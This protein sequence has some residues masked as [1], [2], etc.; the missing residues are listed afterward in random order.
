M[1]GVVRFEKRKKLNPQYVGPFEILEKIG[2]VAYRIASTPEYANAH[3]VF[4]VSM[5]RK[6]VAD[7]THVL[8]Q[9]SMELERNLQ[10]E[11]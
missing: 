2:P 10:Y 9:P 1:K 5:L 7:P 11:E 6:Y 3:D 8:E 4:H